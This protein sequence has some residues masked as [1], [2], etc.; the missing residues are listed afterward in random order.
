MSETD[1]EETDDGREVAASIFD[2][3]ATTANAVALVLPEPFASAVKV[4]AG[5]ASIVGKLI[6][7]IGT[8]NT[9]ELMKELQRRRDEGKITDAH[10]ARD[11]AEIADAVSALYS[12]GNEEGD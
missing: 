11:N 2:G 7:S 12:K 8:D 4:G 1:T 10:V 5:L 6:R 9:K 3:A